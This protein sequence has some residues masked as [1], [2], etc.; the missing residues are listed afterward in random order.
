MTDREQLL[1]AIKKVNSDDSGKVIANVSGKA[2]AK[3]FW[4]FQPLVKA[5][6]GRLHKQYS[7][8]SYEDHVLVGDIA[9]LKA[10]KDFGKAKNGKQ[11]NDGKVVNEEIEEYFIHYASETIDGEMKKAYGNGPQT[12]RSRTRLATILKKL[13]ESYSDDIND[14]DAFTSFI[15]GLGDNDSK[16][17]I[18]S[19]KIR[20]AKSE[21]RQSFNAMSLNEQFNSTEPSDNEI[22]TRGDQLIAEREEGPIDKERKLLRL[23]RIEAEIEQ[24]DI[25]ESTKS[26][27]KLFLKDPSSL[28]D[29]ETLHKAG[30]VGLSD[31]DI[32]RWLVNGF[33]ALNTQRLMNV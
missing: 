31:T 23:Q 7:W 25:D 10:I 14:E 11:E 1:I 26:L 21:L 13:F 16:R 33:K 5:I 20:R 24:V 2:I 29:T 8:L 6:A 22:E 32:Y 30:L 9:L 28:K 15:E 17:L 12:I 4:D 3:L 18:D 27:L 19:A